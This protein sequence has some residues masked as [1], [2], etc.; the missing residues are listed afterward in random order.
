MILCLV[1]LT[2]LY[3]RLVGLSASAELLVYM[4][5]AKHSAVYATATWLGGWL[6][7]CLSIIR[8]YCIKT[9]KPVLKR[10]RPSASHIILVSSELCTVPIPGE[11]LQRRYKYTGVEKVG[12]FRRKSPFTSEMVRDRPMLIMERQ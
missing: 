6:G 8:R 3:T 1:S 10:C 9:A 5:D 11:P 7:G 12:D 4:R 2:D